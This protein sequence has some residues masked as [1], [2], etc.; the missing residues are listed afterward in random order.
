MLE[1]INRHCA[2]CSYLEQQHLNLGTMMMCPSSD[3]GTFYMAVEFVPV[4]NLEY[5]EK[6]ADET[7]R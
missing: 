6:K 3:Y 2:N 4:T 1:N 7:I 5:L